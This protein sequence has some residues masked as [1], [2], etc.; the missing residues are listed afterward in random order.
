M[1]RNEAIAIL[2]IFSKPII[3]GCVVINL[4]QAQ[5]I[6]RRGRHA[7]LNI[8]LL[9]LLLLSIVGKFTGFFF[10]DEASDGCRKK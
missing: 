10:S 3:S 1:Y 2:V 9:I 5:L 6:Q 8:M 4:R 7:N